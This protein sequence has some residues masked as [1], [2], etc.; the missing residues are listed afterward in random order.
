MRR[1]STIYT[2]AA[3]TRDILQGVLGGLVAQPSFLGAIG[4]P[5]DSFIGLIVALYNIGCMAGCLVAGAY[6]NRLG[7][8]PT[9]IWGSVIMVVGGTIQAATYGSTQLIVGRLVSGVGNGTKNPPPLPTGEFLSVL[10]TD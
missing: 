1:I 10:V 4:N 5:S 8:K 3:L 9:I 6:G 2:K 7:R